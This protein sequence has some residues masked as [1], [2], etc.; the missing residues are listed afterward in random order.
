MLKEHL[1]TDEVAVIE[2]GLDALDAALADLGYCLT[3]RMES[4][5]DSVRRKLTAAVTV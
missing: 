5:R 4:A 2:R 1:T 3:P